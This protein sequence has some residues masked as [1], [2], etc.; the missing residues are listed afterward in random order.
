MPVTEPLVLRADVLII[1]VSRLAE[2]VRRV[3]Q[4]DTSDYAVTLRHGRSG[5]RIVTP[6]TARFLERFREPHRVVDVVREY[7]RQHGLSPDR[8]LSEIF[9]VVSDCFNRRF[10]VPASSPEASRM[11]PQLEPGS[12]LRGYR[13]RRSLH[14]LDDTE[15]Y[16]AES[17]TGRTVAIK[18]ARRGS[19]RWRATFSREAAVLRKLGGR[20]A[21]RLLEAGQW[22]R[23]PFLVMSWCAGVP[24]ATL[25]T[26]PEDRQAIRVAGAILAQ[27]ARL[28]AGG[29]LH[30]DVHP[31]N[32]LIDR[33]GRVWLLDF[34][35]AVVLR[36]RS[37]GPT[38]GGVA[39][40]LDPEYAAALLRGEPDPPLTAAAEQYSLAALVY[41]LLAGDHYLEFGLERDSMLR[42][43][44]EDDPL[45]FA[46]RK[47][48]P[49]PAV[50]A[51]L[52]R[53]LCKNP[54]GRFRSVAAFGTALRK[55]AA[56]ERRHPVAANRP[57]ELEDAVEETLQLLDPGGR[58]FGAPLEPPSCSVCYGSAGIGFA[59]Y[60]L[61][62]LRGDAGLLAAADSWLT[63]AERES[64]DPGAWH[65]PAIDMGADDVGPISFLNS[66]AGL[67]AARA[68]LANAVGDPDG[69]TRAVREFVAASRAPCDTLDL[70]LGRAGTLLGTTL[71][72]E[73]LPAGLP[74]PAGALRDLAAGTS[75]FLAD[76]IQTLPPA[77][78]GSGF[79]TLGMAHGWAGLLYALLRCQRLSGGRRPSWMEERLHQ[80]AALAE[81]VGRGLGWPHTVPPEPGAAPAAGWCRGAAGFVHLWTEAHAATGN[82]EYLQLAEGSGWTAWEATEPMSNLCCGVAGRGY[83]L[84]RLYR[85]TGEPVWLDR[86]RE[87][88]LHAVRS[89]RHTAREPG[90]MSLYKHWLG[91]AL[92]AADLS[93]PELSSMPLFESEGW[94]MAVTRTDD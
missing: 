6:E 38:R 90:A 91:I 72:L 43:I 79:R 31:G 58:L 87:L 46:R 20:C 93:R 94:P 74:D 22:R 35:Q 48:A 89:L 40:Y 29:V 4:A 11:E 73:L 75:R 86:A 66:T 26:G 54:G 36:G 28:H 9:P 76:R 21:P 82:G 25:C 49:W 1:P 47:A 8:L 88:T 7:S 37:A 33:R 78:A 57:H 63:R 50:E 18:L 3:I 59:L 45:P 69:L 64:G 41:S 23:R 60:R 55:A 83:A 52:A 71:L 27:Y 81:P 92:L 2:R 67:H 10:L 12:R 17:S 15:V 5:S 77:G 51:V 30:G 32:I 85:H 53:A 61:A 84:L 62:S 16:Q 44:T 68:H 42:Q 56:S 13:I 34:G 39:W 19:G 24:P 65:N 70:F 14:L 80:L